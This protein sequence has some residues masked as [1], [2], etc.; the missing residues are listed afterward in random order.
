MAGG[1]A[2]SWAHIWGDRYTL[3]AGKDNNTQELVH[4]YISSQSWGLMSLT[5]LQSKCNKAP[6]VPESTHSLLL[7]TSTSL[8]S[9]V[10]GSFFPGPSSISTLCLS[11]LPASL[12]GLM[13]GM[14]PDDPGGC[15]AQGLQFDPICS[16]FSTEGHKSTGLTISTQVPLVDKSHLTSPKVRARMIQELWFL[17]LQ[18]RNQKLHDR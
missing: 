14:G 11:P 4:A 8:T 10:H 5:R 1:L 7:P 18:Q 12:E 3:V 17:W 2:N 15:P 13:V 6:E 16:P 9:L